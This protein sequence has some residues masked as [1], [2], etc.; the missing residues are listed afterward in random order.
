MNVKRLGKNLFDNTLFPKTISDVSYYGQFTSASYTERWR[1][2]EIHLIAGIQ[3]TLS[4]DISCDATPFNISVGVGKGGYSRDIAQVYNLSSGRVSIPF[5]ITTTDIENFGDILAFRAPRYS[6]STTFNFTISNVQLEISA[7]PTAFE[8]YNSTTYS[9][10]WQTEAGTVYAGSIDLT[11][12]VLTVTHRYVTIKEQVGLSFSK[13]S[14]ETADTYYKNISSWVSDLVVSGYTEIA[15]CD[16]FKPE[17]STNPNTIFIQNQYLNVRT[18]VNEYATAADFLTWVQT[19]GISFV[20]ELATPQTYQL[21]PTEVMAILGTN[22]IFANTGD[23]SLQ[24]PTEAVG[25]IADVLINDG[26]TASNTTWSS[27]MINTQLSS[28]LDYKD[29]TGTLT[30]GST[31]I[32]LSDASIT[33][34]STIDVYTDQE[35]PHNSMSVTTGSVTITFDAQQ[36]DVNVKVRVS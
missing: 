4:F 35:L 1:I 26:R 19:N 13:S 33:T 34:S 23:V 18:P 16:K 7:V 24:Y 29:L 25:D 36:S 28:K 9:V 31:S 2:P 10:T 8:P 11:T 15:A 27:T 21:T 14:I 17:R 3:Y 20:F 6:V 32:T 5:S 30:A 22:N 12:G